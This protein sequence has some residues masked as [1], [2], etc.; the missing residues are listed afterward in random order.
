VWLEMVSFYFVRIFALA[1]GGFVKEFNTMF[2]SGRLW[3]G[4]TRP[5]CPAAVILHVKLVFTLICPLRVCIYASTL[6]V[7]TD[8]NKGGPGC[9]GLYAFA[10]E[11]GPFFWTVDGELFANPYS[12]NLHAN[13]LYVETPVGVGFSYSDVQD[14]YITGDAQTAI[15]NYM[16][17]IK[18]LER[19]PE[20]Q[21]N[22]LYVASES[23]GGHYIP[24]CKYGFGKVVVRI[25]FFDEQGIPTTTNDVSTY[26]PIGMRECV[27]ILCRL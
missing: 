3:E 22:D 16:L 18:F 21:S 9:S 26:D 2:R 5:F 4:I 11:H 10:V 1:T 12:W 23:Y 20:R 15:D 17:I 19:F 7:Y 6:L 8:P 25:S 13:I 24:G 14:D 27:M